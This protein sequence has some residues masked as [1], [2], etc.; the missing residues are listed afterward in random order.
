MPSLLWSL[1]VL[2]FRKSRFPHQMGVCAI[3]FQRKG[4][5]WRWK[6]GD[7]GRMEPVMESAPLAE[8][9]CRWGVLSAS[10][11]TAWSGVRREPSNLSFSFCFDIYLFFPFFSLIPPY[12]NLQINGIVSKPV[13]AS[14]I[15][16]I[17]CLQSGLANTPGE[18]LCTDH[19]KT[20]KQKLTN[21]VGYEA[22]LG[23]EWHYLRILLVS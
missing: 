9:W 1:S 13:D 19:T 10:A 20:Q 21:L 5:R 18:H 17:R 7:F 23:I 22:T 6:E 11:W 14:T 12:H 2:V 15:Q 16:V 4:D 3:V 8:E